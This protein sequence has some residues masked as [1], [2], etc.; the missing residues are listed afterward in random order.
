[1]SRL[2]MLPHAADTDDWYTPQ[3]IFE[4]MNVTFDLD[5]CAPPG[6]VPWIP[7]IRSFSIDDDGLVQPW[8]GFIWCNPPYSAPFA[9]CDKWVIH[10]NG[11]IVLRAD[12][13]S[14]GPAAAFAAATSLFVPTPRL[15]FVNGHGEKQ[16]SV[17]FSTVLLG[18]GED[19]DWA[20]GGLVTRGMVRQL[21]DMQ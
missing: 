16:G 12:L 2:F 5:V 1:M 20:L 21:R 13:S 17:N 6:G 10:G 18:V 15:Q 4:K 11:V 14:R 3:W 9:W 8:E 7:A 19:A